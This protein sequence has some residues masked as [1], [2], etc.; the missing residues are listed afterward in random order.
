MKSKI[1]ILHIISTSG[2]GGAQ[3]L[4]RDIVKIIPPQFI[5]SMLIP[6]KAMSPMY[7]FMYS[8]EHI[9]ESFIEP[10]LM[11]ESRKDSINPMMRCM[12]GRYNMVLEK[13]LMPIVG[14]I[15]I[16]GD[17]FRMFLELHK[18][19]IRYCPTYLMMA[20]VAPKEFAKEKYWK[21]FNPG[22]NLNLPCIG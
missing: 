7:T 4:L 21:N 15:P 11:G 3:T 5:D 20:I 10:C 19:W 9:I 22:A 17:L 18:V 1:R 6:L 12:E 2:L 13:Y 8:F 14:Q 16:I